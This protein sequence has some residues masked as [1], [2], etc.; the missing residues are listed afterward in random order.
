MKAS[1]PCEAILLP[2]FPINKD[3]KSEFLIFAQKSSNSAQKQQILLRG[4]Q[5]TGNFS[6]LPSTAAPTVTYAVLTR[7]DENYQGNAQGIF[8]CY[9]HEYRRSLASAFV[10]L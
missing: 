1:Q 6:N 7:D 3:I 9:P 10:S 5:L 2:D 4:R 8:S